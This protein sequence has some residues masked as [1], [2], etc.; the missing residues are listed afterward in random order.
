MKRQFAIKV[1]DGRVFI[2]LIAHATTK[3]IVGRLDNDTSSS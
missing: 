3:L 2:A 1:F